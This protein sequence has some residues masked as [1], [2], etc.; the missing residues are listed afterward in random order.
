MKTYEQKQADTEKYLSQ[1]SNDQLADLI[2]ANGEPEEV[3]ALVDEM[4]SR[5]STA[6]AEAAYFMRNADKWR[7]RYAEELDRGL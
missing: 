1:L 2:K 6:M 4:L 7:K 3:E 5:L